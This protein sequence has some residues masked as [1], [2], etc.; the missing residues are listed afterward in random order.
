MTAIASQLVAAPASASLD[1]TLAFISPA[2]A[3][4]HIGVPFTF[5]PYA[6]LLGVPNTGG[7]FYDESGTLPNGIG[8]S[9]LVGISG[10]PAPDSEGTYHFTWYAAELGATSASQSFTLTVV[11]SPPAAEPTLIPQLV[12]APRAE[13]PTSASFA[14]SADRSELDNDTLGDCVEV[15][16]AHLTIDQATAVGLHAAPPSARAVTAMYY[17]ITGGAA[18]SDIGT[19]N[20]QAFAR[21]KE[22]GLA[23]YRL[24]GVGRLAG[25]AHRRVLETAVS[26]LGGAIAY[27]RVPR[28][29]Q[30]SATSGGAKLWA[31]GA[32]STTPASGLAHEVA[33]VGYNPIGPLLS[34]WGAVR[35]ATWSW[36]ARYAQEVYPVVTS[37]LVAAGHGPSGIPVA[38][39]LR[40]WTDATPPAAVRKAHRRWRA[41]NPVTW[42]VSEPRQRGPH[43]FRS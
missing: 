19:N 4:A 27:V 10:A 31:A 23:G 33:V 42:S 28:R 22:D 18:G 8:Y 40:T 21:W 38:R 26:E 3:V 37:A 9:P 12:H 7:A 30:P 29:D 13:V 32:S 1:A 35:Q 36:W 34:T 25:A 5:D 24:V 41:R 20:R 39:L 6:R 43:E 11:S 16:A 14:T 2:A 17:A 15:A